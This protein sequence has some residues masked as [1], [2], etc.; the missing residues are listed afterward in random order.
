MPAST[1]TKG[2]LPTRLSLVQWWRHWWRSLSPMRQDRFAALAPLAAVLLFMAA[3]VAAFWYLRVEE[4]ER[5]QEA[6][7]RDVEYAQQRVR[8]RLLERQEQLMRIARDLSNH[9][10]E[11]TQFD[12]RAEA[13]VSQY[14]ELQP[15]TW[16]DDRGRIRASHAAPAARPKAAASFTM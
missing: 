11:R 16:I 14:P 5:E 3:I 7:R 12:Q 15:I 13:L 9:D 4:G 6:L 8:L 2:L 10:M 1:P